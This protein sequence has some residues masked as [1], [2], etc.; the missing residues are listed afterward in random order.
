[1]TRFIMSTIFNNWKN[2]LQESI[3][4]DIMYHVTSKDRLDSI[5]ENGLKINS[6]L[7]KTR[8]AENYMLDVYPFL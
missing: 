5:K 2:F 7:G 4:K 3:Q 6:A 1:M 8:A